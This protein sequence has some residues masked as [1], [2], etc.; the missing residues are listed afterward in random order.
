MSYIDSFYEGYAEFRQDS[1]SDF[2]YLDTSGNI[3]I[4]GRWDSVFSFKC[5]YAEVIKGDS[6]GLINTKGQLVLNTAYDYIR[7]AGE[8][9][10]LFEKDDKWGAIHLTMNEKLPCEY[11]ELD[12]LGDGFFNGE[13]VDSWGEKTWEIVNI[14]TGQKFSHSSR[15]NISNVFNGKILIESN[16][17]F[18]LLDG[19]TGEQEAVS[20]PV[21]MN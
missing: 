18:I 4:S 13:K 19:W 9:V 11:N 3:T 8:D 20:Q 5:G 1:G 12:Y 7:R 21:R 15:Q 10:Y 6:Y 17:Q 14:A 16:D 2:G